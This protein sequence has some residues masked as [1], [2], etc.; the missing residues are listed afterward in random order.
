MTD[1][2]LLG[3]MAVVC[4]AAGVIAGVVVL[5]SARDTLLALRFA[6]D[7]WLAAGLLRLAGEP[8]WQLLAGAAGIIVVRQL[9]SLGLRTS[10]A[11]LKS[12]RDA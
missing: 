10:P 5:V 9:A 3:Q 11:A 4:T 12:R 8:T 2:Q 6:V 7:F 1:T